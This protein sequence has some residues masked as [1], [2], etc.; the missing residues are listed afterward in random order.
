MQRRC[1]CNYETKGEARQEK[2]G[3]SD[4][5]LGG[6]SLYLGITKGILGAA[7]DTLLHDGMYTLSGL[8]MTPLKTLAAV[9]R[10]PGLPAGQGV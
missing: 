10:S 6:V 3:P 8:A 1:K 5:R 4:G 7:S 9:P 2:W